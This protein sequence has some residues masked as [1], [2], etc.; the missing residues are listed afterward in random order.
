MKEV[1]I[2]RFLTFSGYKENAAKTT[3]WTLLICFSQFDKNRCVLLCTEGGFNL[4]LH[5]YNKDAHRNP[6]PGRERYSM[7][8]GEIAFSSTK[9]LLLNGGKYLKQGGS[10]VGN[11]GG[12]IGYYQMFHVEHCALHSFDKTIATHNL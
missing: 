10:Y 3:N 7:V 9:E 5:A 6:L 8:Q 1:F 12:L 11:S 4:L 2:L